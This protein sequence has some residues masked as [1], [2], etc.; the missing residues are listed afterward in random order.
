MA[1]I[2]AAVKNTKH[3]NSINVQYAYKRIRLADAERI[4]NSS[5]R[6][7]KD[8]RCQWTTYEKLNQWCDD[9]KPV[10]LKYKFADDRKVWICIIYIFNL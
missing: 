3:Q 9:T 7:V 6:E 2:S 4:Q 10:L 5:V 8:I 1:I